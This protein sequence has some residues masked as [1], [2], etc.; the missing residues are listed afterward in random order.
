MPYTSKVNGLDIPISSDM[1]RA[2]SFFKTEHS[3][4]VI[5][6]GKANV[7]LQDPAQVASEVKRLEAQVAALKKQ[8]EKKPSSKKP[9]TADDLS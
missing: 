9:E 2:A 6:D 7:N 1:G 4:T 5:D 8:G 3:A